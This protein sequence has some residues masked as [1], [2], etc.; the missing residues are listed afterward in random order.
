MTFLAGIIIHAL[1]IGKMVRGFL[2]SIPRE[3]WYFIAG[4]AAFLFAWHLIAQHDRAKW[5]AGYNVAWTQGQQRAAIQ[6]ASIAALK[7][8]LA[9]K[10]RESDARAAAFAE[11]AAQS[12]RD[13]AAADARLRA[14]KGRGETLR[15][16]AR[17][18]PDSG[19]KVP[20]ALAAQL[21][22]L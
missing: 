4:V 22:G 1:G 2:G 21:K 6:R 19:C 16:L 12:S 3:V 18:L 17:D 13:V 10:N 14:D 15:A 8:A 9:M 20:S 11:S 7:N 5:N